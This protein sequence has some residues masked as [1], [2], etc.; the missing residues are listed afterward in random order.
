MQRNIEII[1]PDHRNSSFNFDIPEVCPICGKTMSPTIS[2]IHVTGL[3]DKNFTVVLLF[4][5]SSD[6]CRKFFVVEYLI[7]SLKEQGYSSYSYTYDGPISYNR[8]PPVNNNLPDELKNISP[9]FLETYNQSLQAELL[10][11]NQIAGIGMRK[12]IEFLIKDYL[13]N[14]KGKDPEKTKSKWLFPA[15]QDIEFEPIKN[16]ATA[17]TWIG[18][19]ETHYVREWQDKDVTDMKAFIRSAALFISADYQVNNSTAM[20]EQKEAE[21]QLAKQQKAN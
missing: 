12:S 11:M 8:V 2:E 5:C 1:R 21:K 3:P 19:D 10:G 20:I 17:A 7:K 14:V 18:N 16:L 15:I 13:I 6:I 9:T 4:R